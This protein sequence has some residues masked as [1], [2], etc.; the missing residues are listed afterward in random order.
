MIPHTPEAVALATVAR[1]SDWWA[2][3][4]WIRLPKTWGLELCFARGYL[5]HATHCG[6]GDGRESWRLTGSGW[7]A[8]KRPRGEA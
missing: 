6:C 3:E 2:P 5:D 4:K 8:L 7:A 1:M